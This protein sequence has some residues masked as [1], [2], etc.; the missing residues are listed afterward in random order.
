[1]SQV[2]HAPWTS[3]SIRLPGSGLDISDWRSMGMDRR[4]S[5][6]WMMIDVTVRHLDVT[7]SFPDRRADLTSGQVV[8]VWTSGRCMRATQRRKHVQSSSNH[9]QI[10]VKY[11]VTVLWHD[12]HTGS[13]SRICVTARPLV[14]LTARNDETHGGCRGSRDGSRLPALSLTTAVQTS[15]SVVASARRMPRVLMM[16][17]IAVFGRVTRVAP[18]GNWAASA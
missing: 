17:S 13:K 16:V 12:I 11:I 3:P 15:S 6:V 4:L 18:S 14:H 2:T 8:Q 1:M 7:S 9:V 5:G 10:Y